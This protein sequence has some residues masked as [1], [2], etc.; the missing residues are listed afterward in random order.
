MTVED[1]LIEL[2]SSIQGAAAI[3]TTITETSPTV[4][5]I[6]TLASGVLFTRVTITETSSTVTT[7]NNK[8]YESD[9]VTVRYEYN[10]VITE[11]SDT[12]TTTVRTVI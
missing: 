1:V 9:G 8:I 6:D 2:G 5:T 12:Q 7:V 10:D 4:T 3:S 11:V